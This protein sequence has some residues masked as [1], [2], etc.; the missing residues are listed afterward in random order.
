METIGILPLASSMAGL[1]WYITSRTA[2][3]GVAV[4]WFLYLYLVYL[5]ETRN[6]A[7]IGCCTGLVWALAR[8]AL[9]R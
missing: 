6:S 3:V 1:G 5:R 4:T 7:T 8:H 2:S 9:G